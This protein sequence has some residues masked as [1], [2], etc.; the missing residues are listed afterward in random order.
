M[1]EWYVY[2]EDVNRK[3]IV[4]YNVFKHYNFCQDLKDIISKLKNKNE[5]SEKVRRIALYY[6]WSKCEYEILI[7]TWIG[8]KDFKDEKVDVYDQLQLNW[9][10]FI[11]YI[12]KNKKVLDRYNFI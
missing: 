5:L 10:A 4:K 6:F 9:N 2:L 1:L 3:K 7:T 11:D 12:W 8:R